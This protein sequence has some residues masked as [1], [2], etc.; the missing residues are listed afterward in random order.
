MALYSNRVRAVG[1]QGQENMKKKI[2]IFSIVFLLLQVI[3]LWLTSISLKIPGISEANPF[4]TEGWF[5]PVK[6]GMILLIAPTIYYISLQ[7][8]F[9][10]NASIYTLLVMYVF[11]CANNAFWV[12]T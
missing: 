9:W 8:K 4:Y 5:V 10:S 11:I 7:S 1:I 12:L 3:D 2:I 6:L